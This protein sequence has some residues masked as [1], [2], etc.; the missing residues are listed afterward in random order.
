MHTASGSADWPVAAEAALRLASRVQR[1][2]GPLDEKVSI[3]AAWAGGGGQ[4]A[5]AELEQW[6]AQEDSY[7]AN[8]KEYAV[9]QAESVGIMV[10][11]ALDRA[12]GLLL[13]LIHI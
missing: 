8:I 11:S 5:A 3:L 6:A 2:L 12:S 1:A 10:R 4:Q 7:L 9:S 13:S